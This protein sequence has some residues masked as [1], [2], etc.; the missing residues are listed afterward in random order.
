M[1]PLSWDVGAR[2]RNMRQHKGINQ[3]Q[4]AARLHVSPTT[5]SH[6]ENGTQTPSIETT[7]NIAIELSCSADYLMGLDDSPKIAI[8]NLTDRERKF[9][10]EAI[11]LFAI[12]NKSKN[13]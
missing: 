8:H 12:K 5:I 3:K 6:Y 9:W 13:R 4:L 2:I 11:D 1:N 7:R 10:Y